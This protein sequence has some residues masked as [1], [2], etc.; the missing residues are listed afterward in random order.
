MLE[1]DVE[2]FYN[3]DHANEMKM[4]KDDVGTPEKL[5]ERYPLFLLAHYKLQQKLYPY[6]VGDSVKKDEKEREKRVSFFSLFLSFLYV[7]IIE[8]F[9]Y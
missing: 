9:K 2:K 4:K 6:R 3:C 8:V 7:F 1:C 5:R